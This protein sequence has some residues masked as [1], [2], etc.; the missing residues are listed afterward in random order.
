MPVLRLEWPDPTGRSRTPLVA[1]RMV[2][3][4]V[5][6]DPDELIDAIHGLLSKHMAARRLEVQLEKSAQRRSGRFAYLGHSRGHGTW[7]VLP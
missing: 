4:D 5:L 2:H 7:K 3:P 1:Q 6:S